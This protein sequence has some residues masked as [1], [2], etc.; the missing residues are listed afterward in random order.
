[1]HRSGNTLDL[2]ITRSQDDIIALPKAFDCSL[3]D[4]YALFF[5]LKLDKLPLPK[6]TVVYRR[7]KEID[8]V[9]L[10]QA[11]QSCPLMSLDMSAMNLNEIANKYNSELSAILDKHVPVRIK[12]ITVRAPTLWYDDEIRAAKQ[13]KRVIERRWRKSELT[14]HR[15]KYIAEQ[16]HVNDLISA[17]KARHF[18][19]KIADMEGDTKRLFQLV[20]SLIRIR[21]C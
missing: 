10:C 18:R 15:E 7:L 19:T 12:T 6:K 13:R 20:I 21:Y 11:I 2:L 8:P 14:V 16:N 4:H 17:A 5:D 9:A 1:M 3:P